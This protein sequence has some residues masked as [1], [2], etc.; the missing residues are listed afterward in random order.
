MDD[1]GL[2]RSVE[3][4]GD[5]NGAVERIVERQRS[6]RKPV[7]ERLAIQELHDEIG[8]RALA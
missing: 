4:G 5:L 1:G 8:H 7:R 3:C 2:M 6:L